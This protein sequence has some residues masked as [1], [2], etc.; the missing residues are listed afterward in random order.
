MLTNEKF[1]C[2]ICVDS[3]YEK[4]FI[5][6]LKWDLCVYMQ[7]CVNLGFPCL[8]RNYSQVSLIGPKYQETEVGHNS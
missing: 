2:A 5:G 3:K 4:G 6:I 7:D 1:E 8:Y